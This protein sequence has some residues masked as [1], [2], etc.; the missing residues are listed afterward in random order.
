MSETAGKEPTLL[1]LDRAKRRG[2]WGEPRFC[3]RCKGALPAHYTLKYC[4][5]CRKETLDEYFKKDKSPEW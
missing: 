3:E 2:T 5:Q 1:E 4:P